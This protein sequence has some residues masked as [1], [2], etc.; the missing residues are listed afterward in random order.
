M[1]LVGDLSGARV[2][3]ELVAILSE[4]R[5]GGALARIAGIG[6]AGA[7]HPAIECGEPAVALVERLD[8]ARNRYAP[9]L[10]AWRG[11]LGAMARAI[12]G[13]ELD[14]WLERLR[15]RR[16]DARV[17]AAAAVVPPRLQSPLERAEE[18]ARVAELLAA[19]PVEVALMVLA[20]GGRAAEQAEIYLER[21]RAVRLDIDGDTL[22]QQFGMQESPLIGEVLAELLRR[23]RNGELG[24]REQ[25]LEAA[26]ELLAEVAG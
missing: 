17:V 26:R 16:R 11:R 5:V 24:G 13:D 2:R 15:V 25:Q 21:L 14:A 6:L 8:A 7:L 18:P 22:R 9:D 20:G 12:P 19:Q 23:R 1:G 4:E 3:D 10:A